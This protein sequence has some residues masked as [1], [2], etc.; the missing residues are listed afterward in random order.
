[1]NFAETYLAQLERF[2]ARGPLPRVRALHLPPAGDAPL[3]GDRGEFCALEL[4][5]GS[6]GLSY[7][8]LDDTLERM[9]EGEGGFALAGADALDLARAYAT[10]SGIR[11]TL[12]FAAA[13]ALTRC[14][15]DRAGY[16]PDTSADS[17]G[18]LDPQPGERIGMIGLFTPLIG[19]ILKS[20]AELTVVELKAELAGD[21]DGYRVTLDP[22][23]LAGCGKVLSTSTLLL[24]DTLDHMLGFCRDARWFAMIGPSAGCLPD[25]LFARGVTLV[26]G[27][28]V[29]DR[30]GFVDALRNGRE[31]GDYA[32][33]CAIAADA[34]PGFEALLATI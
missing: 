7:V 16:R 33:K 23:E 26:G 3:P 32:R 24:N 9:R 6:L 18:G 14:F 25:A 19:R 21:R 1:M 12:G 20:G 8:L 11:R 13:N 4:D 15:F 34:Y 17:I 31:R 10:G 2:A 28:W 5:D 22:A 27:T 30:E 29:Q